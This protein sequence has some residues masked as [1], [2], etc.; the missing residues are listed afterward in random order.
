MRPEKPKVPTK[1]C[2][3]CIHRRGDMFTDPD[4]TT[5]KDEPVTRVYCRALHSKVDVDAMTKHCDHWKLKPKE[6]RV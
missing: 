6:D 2:E 1:A 5:D 3:T 4:M